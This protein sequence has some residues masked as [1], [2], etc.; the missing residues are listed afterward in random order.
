MNIYQP[1]T[2]TRYVICHG[3]RSEER[4]RY[5]T[6][7]QYWFTNKMTVSPNHVKKMSKWDKLDEEQV[8]KS[9]TN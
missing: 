4:Q 5:S 9:S 6:E 8:K 7:I 1:P 3:I 2:L